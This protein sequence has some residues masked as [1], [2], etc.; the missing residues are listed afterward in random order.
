MI[1]NEIKTYLEKYKYAL[2]YSLL[3]YSFFNLINNR[4]TWRCCF[5]IAV[6]SEL[7]PIASQIYS[8]VSH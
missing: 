2:I 7:I 6:H 1:A 8:S 4:C 5:Y 3:L